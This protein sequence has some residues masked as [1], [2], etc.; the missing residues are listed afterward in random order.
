MLT[1]R[2]KGKEGQGVGKWEGEGEGKEGKRKE[3]RRGEGTG[4]DGRKGKGNERNRRATKE[5]PQL[6]TGWPGKQEDMTF[7]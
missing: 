4:K 2:I 1:Y 3:E 5:T 7:L 6:V